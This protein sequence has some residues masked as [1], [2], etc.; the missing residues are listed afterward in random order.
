MVLIVL[1][2]L[3]QLFHLSTCGQLKLFCS[4]YSGSKSPKDIRI[5]TPEFNAQE[6]IQALEPRVQRVPS[7]TGDR[8][9][10]PP[11]RPPSYPSPAVTPMFDN[12]YG[13]C[14]TPSPTP[15]LSDTRAHTFEDV[16]GDHED[17]QDLFDTS[18]EWKYI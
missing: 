2:F 7:V 1:I 4:V 13:G 3:Q 12:L 9:A 14:I 5:T 16:M 17:F 6:V 11:S 18:L 15:P 10:R 8:G